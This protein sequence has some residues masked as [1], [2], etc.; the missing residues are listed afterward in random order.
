MCKV[1]AIR[2][3]SINIIKTVSNKQIIMVTFHYNQNAKTNTD[4]DSNT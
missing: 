2:Y 3:C 1:T 4:S